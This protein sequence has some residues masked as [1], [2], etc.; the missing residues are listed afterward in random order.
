[1]LLVKDIKAVTKITSHTG[2]DVKTARNPV[3]GRRAQIFHLR[4]STLASH[5]KASKMAMA[6]TT[7]RPR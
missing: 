5:P 6:Q 1:M 2:R 3:E 7:L 4:E